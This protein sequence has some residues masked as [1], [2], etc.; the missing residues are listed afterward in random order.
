MS[1]C[2]AYHGMS[3]SRKQTLCPR[4]LRARTSARK[5]VACPLPHEEVIDRPK[6][7]MSNGLVMRSKL[8]RQRSLV[9]SQLLCQA[10]AEAAT[11]DAGTCAQPKLF[12]M[13]LVRSFSLSRD[14]NLANDAQLHPHHAPPTP[15]G[16]ASRTF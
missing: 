16:L 9:L 13:Q 1:R 6:I 8:L 7:T 11:H 3:R 15:R 14:P 4:A 12:A 5:V 10:I 2:S